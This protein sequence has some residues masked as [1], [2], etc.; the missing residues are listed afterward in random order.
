MQELH[1]GAPPFAKIKNDI[2]VLLKYQHGERP[3][4][5]AKNGLKNSNYPDVCMPID[6]ATWNSTL[7]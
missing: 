5:P 3:P 4:R 6:D 2:A 7:R 1:T